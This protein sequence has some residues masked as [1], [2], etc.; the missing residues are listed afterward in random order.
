MDTWVAVWI[1]LMTIGTML[2]MS[3]YSGK[4]LLQA[5]VIAGLVLTGGF[6]YLLMQMLYYL[7]NFLNGNS[8]IPKSIS[9]NRIWFCEECIV[10]KSYVII[11]RIAYMFLRIWNNV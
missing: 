5:S 1:A 7:L 10:N 11:G 8:F 6:I 4:I 3:V 9:G 2:P